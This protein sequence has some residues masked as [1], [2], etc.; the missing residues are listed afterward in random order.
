MCLEN[1]NLRGL[2][3]EKIEQ[4]QTGTRKRPN[5]NQENE[6]KPN[7]N[8]EITFVQKIFTDTSLRNFKDTVLGIPHDIT[9]ITAR[10]SVCIFFSGIDSGICS[11][12][13]YCKY[14]FRNSFS[15]FYF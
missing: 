11:K 14:F 8:Q 5:R 13:T 7:K 15:D 2:L 12:F 6:N 3:P 9:S 10:I 4:T 1:R